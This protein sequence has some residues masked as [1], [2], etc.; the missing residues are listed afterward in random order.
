MSSSW[1]LFKIL[2]HL[3]SSGVLPP[4]ITASFVKG[5]E[6]E[7][8]SVD[9]ESCFFKRLNNVWLLWKKKKKFFRPS[10]EME[11]TRWKHRTEKGK[12]EIDRER[13]GGG[14]VK[15]IFQKKKN[16]HTKLFVCLFVCINDR[17]WHR[18]P[19]RKDTFKSAVAITSTTGQTVKSRFPNREIDCY[20]R[21]PISLTVI[22]H[23]DS[24]SSDRKFESG[25]NDIL[26]LGCSRMHTFKWPCCSHTHTHTQT[27]RN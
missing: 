17:P 18:N 1:E 16:F 6:C 25:C 19:H 3:S 26:P 2:I 27:R 15:I 11:S 8:V 23:N 20:Y 12:R 14:K 10:S 24:D 4:V 21:T 9:D 7:R 22:K 13:R 5:E